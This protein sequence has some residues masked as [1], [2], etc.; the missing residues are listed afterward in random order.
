MLILANILIIHQFGEGSA[1]LQLE[2]DFVQVMITAVAFG[3]IVS[4]G[5]GSAADLMT[6]FVLFEIRK[7]PRYRVHSLPE[8]AGPFCKP[9]NLQ[10]SET[11]HRHLVGPI[12]FSP[13][14]SF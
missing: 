9:L 10:M 5:H 14:T 11:L 2:L 7:S 3:D 4:Q 13:F 1:R 8:I 6:K 12:I